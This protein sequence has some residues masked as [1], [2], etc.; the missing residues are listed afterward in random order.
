MVSP[1]SGE[2]IEQ[3]A[4]CQFIYKNKAV[5]C[6][7]VWLHRTTSLCV[8]TK[9]EPSI[10]NYFGTT[11]ETRVGGVRGEGEGGGRGG[12]GTFSWNSLCKKN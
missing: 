9:G 2:K 12:K 3:T 11:S 1:F 4:Q 10:C 7:G 5:P 8:P 6:I